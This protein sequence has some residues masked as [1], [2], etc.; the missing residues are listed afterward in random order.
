MVLASGCTQILYEDPKSE[1]TVK[2][3]HFLVDPQWQ[4]FEW[5]FSQSNYVSVNGLKT[6]SEILA[7]LQFLFENGLLK[8]VP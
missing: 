5:V 3:N 4:N 6:K 2:V 1:V 7:M 8:A